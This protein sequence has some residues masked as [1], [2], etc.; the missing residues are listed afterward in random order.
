MRARM[1]RMQYLAPTVAARTVLSVLRHGG[2]YDFSQ[3]VSE[4]DSSR[5]RIVRQGEARDDMGAPLSVKA[6]S[7][8][9]R[10]LM[11]AGV[12]E[13]LEEYLSRA[14]FVDD[15]G[16]VQHGA[17]EQAGGAPEV[18]TSLNYA[19]TTGVCQVNET[20]CLS[21]L[22]RVSIAVEQ[23]AFHHQQMAELGGGMLVARRM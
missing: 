10:M 14:G 5:A 2:L 22:E 8:E 23:E 4:A 15:D 19:C 7:L 16:R 1:A 20:D 21:A 13:L 9:C 6:L 12:P 3:L 18:V 11:H 17:F